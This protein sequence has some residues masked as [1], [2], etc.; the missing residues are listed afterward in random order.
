MIG[1]D[2]FSF[3]LKQTESWWKHRTRRAFWELH[4]MTDS[5]NTPPQKLAL[6]FVNTPHGSSRF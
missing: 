6:A 4:G 1:F 3:I 5:K 2:M